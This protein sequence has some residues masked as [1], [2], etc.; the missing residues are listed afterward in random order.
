LDLCSTHARRLRT[1][2]GYRKV[3]VSGVLAFTLRLRVH[4]FQFSHQQ[5]PQT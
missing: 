3:C 2:T 1:I 4:A 5:F